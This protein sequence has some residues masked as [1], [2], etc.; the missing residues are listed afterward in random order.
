MNVTLAPSFVANPSG[1]GTLGLVWE[2]LFTYFL[3]LW[4]VVHPNAVSSDPIFETKSKFKW[5]CMIF[6]LPEVAL[7]LVVA[8]YLTAREV[9]SNANK[10]R[11]YRDAERA[12]AT[13][14]PDKDDVEVDL[15]PLAT[16]SEQSPPKIQH[17]SN[18]PVTQK[19]VGWG[20]KWGLA[21]G[22]F[23]QMG[24][25][26]F[27]LEESVE[28]EFAT[29]DGIGQLAKCNMLPTVKFVDEK[30]HVLRKAD[31]LAKA[32]V[33][34]QVSWLIIQTIARRVEE[35]PV[36][37]LELNTIA[38]VWITLVIYG[39]WWFKPQGIEDTVEIDFSNCPKC[40]EQL[41]EN[42]VTPSQTHLFKSAKNE[43]TLPLARGAALVIICLIQIVSSLYIAI[44]ALGW[45]AYFPTRAE[46]IVWQVCICMLAASTFFF[47]IVTR[48][49]AIDAR[50]EVTGWF[51]FVAMLFAVT[52]RIVLMIES[53]ISIRSL[54]VGAYSTPSWSDFIPHIG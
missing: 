15:E 27:K 18:C 25:I 36:T 33:C 30:T 17:E 32:L 40:Q 43:D 23:V 49:V 29:A 9:R 45:T 12:I 46:M 22:Y 52:G 38:Q 24:A 8:E 26:K 21:Q 31:K 34:L 47:L 39:L 1:R 4:T 19:I 11:D 3:C 16:S 41:S 28:A 13:G 2:C 51:V 5:C 44:D 54:P 10:D 48:C 37:L 14:K 42:G 7:A 50:S 53:F 20:P 35:L 6:F